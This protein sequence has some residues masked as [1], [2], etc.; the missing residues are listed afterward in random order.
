VL[1]LFFCCCSRSVSRSGSDGYASASASSRKRNTNIPPPDLGPGPAVHHIL[2]RR[3]EVAQYRRH[4]GIDPGKSAEEEAVVFWFAVGGGCAC[5][6]VEVGYGRGREV[7]VWGEEEGA[8]ELRGGGYC[9][10]EGS[11]GALGEEQVALGEV[12]EDLFEEF[13][14]VQGAEGCCVVWGCCGG[15]GHVV[16]H[17]VSSRLVSCIFLP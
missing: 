7:G 11:G 16:V 2:S 10:V 13:G 6:G 17:L 4:G 9:L 8:L 5:G 3:R 1:L 15:G 14:E 12:G